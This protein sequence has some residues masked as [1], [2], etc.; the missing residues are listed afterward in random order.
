MRAGVFIILLAL[1]TSI[2]G[3]SISMPSMPWSHSSLPADPGAEALFQEGNRYF[4]NK[5]YTRAIDLFQRLKADYPFSP[6]LTAT[7]LKIADAYFLNKQYPEALNAFKE[8]QGL[9]PTNENIPFV[10]Y[11]LG[12]AHFEQFTSID[13]DQK[14]TELAKG[15]FATVITNYPKSPY[16]A[17]AK[18]K[19]AKCIE[20]LAEHDFNVAYF[21]YEQEKFPAARDRFEEIVRKYQDTPTAVKSLF[22]L[23]ESYRKE[24]N[25][26]KAALAYQALIEHYPESRFVP[27]AQAQLAQLKNEKHDP[28]AMLL[29][30]DQRPVAAPAPGTQVAAQDT[31]TGKLKELNLIAKTEI[32]HEEPGDDKTFLSRVADKLNPF[33]SSDD[34]NEVAKKPESGIDVLVNYQQAKKEKSSGFFASLWPFGSSDT[35]GDNPKDTAGSSV[36]L[37]RID[38]SLKQ[39]GIDPAPQQAALHPPAADLPKVDD[40]PPQTANNAK[41]LDEIDSGLEKSGK[42]GAV[43]PPTPQAAAFFKAPASSQVA[44]AK[45][46]PSE[47]SQSPSDS[48]LLSSIDQ[49][50]ESNGV[51]PS[52]FKLPP[53]AVESKTSTP[54]KEPINKVELQPKLAVKKGPLF[55]APTEVP[56]Q[57]QSD[58]AQKTSNADKKSE[59]PTKQQETAES[60]ALESAVKGPSLIQPAAPPPKPEEPKPASSVAEDEEPQGVFD[61]LKRDIDGVKNVLNPFQW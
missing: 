4:N 12:Q 43:L 46:K 58:S 38:A 8:F 11:R 40:A 47:S 26:V 61:S 29:M 24:E 7:E 17:E 60:Q 51:N 19:L 27:Q 3:C 18:K 54:E 37:N 30:R 9:H 20:Y 39:K 13:R 31:K 6:L 32:V 56:D 21:Y 42:S 59:L 28:L 35:N 23:G 41:L 44:V 55:L 34:D 36:A 50:L 14:N 48:G 15:Y 45:A 22:Y 25:G 49:K 53:P 16:A 1:V 57:K 5:S 33:S 52:Q 2:S 10:T